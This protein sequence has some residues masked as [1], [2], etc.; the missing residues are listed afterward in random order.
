MGR[1]IRPSGNVSKPLPPPAVPNSGA[2]GMEHLCLDGLASGVFNWSGGNAFGRFGRRPTGRLG[3]HRGRRQR[4]FGCC[5]VRAVGQATALRGGR[6]GG[7]RR[8]ACF[9]RTAL[10]GRTARSRNLFGALGAYAFTSQRLL[11]LLETGN[12]PGNTAQSERET[13][14]R[15]QHVRLATLVGA[16]RP[17]YCTVPFVA[18]TTRR[19]LGRNANSSAVRLNAPGRRFVRK[20]IVTPS[21]RSSVPV[22][23]PI[24]RLSERQ[25]RARAAQSC[26]P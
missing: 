5:R 13:P 12:N 17:S 3:G 25:A 8:Q 26:A 18:P 11:F 14:E 16:P 6:R 19:A 4:R 1:G 7:R 9:R 10:S 2:P 22:P 21:G 20:M 23:V 24:S 15:G